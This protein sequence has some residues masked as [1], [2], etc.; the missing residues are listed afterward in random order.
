MIQSV[1]GS[2][3]QAGFAFA[4]PAPLAAPAAKETEASGNSN[5]SASTRSAAKTEKS[6]PASTASVDQLSS[7]EQQQL[8]QLKQIDRLVRAHEQAHLVVGSNLVRGGASFAYQTGPDDQRYAVGGE[9]SIDASPAATP[10][11]TIPKAQHIR[12]AALAPA[13]PSPQDQIVAAVAGRMEGE[14]RME[15]ALRQS[16]SASSAGQGSA[17]FYQGVEQNVSGHA[18]LGEGLDIFA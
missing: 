2:S 1:A 16:G 15:L 3:L 4:R 14:A 7:Q 11:E 6:S 8:A 13:D 5:D 17:D 12:A 18:R 9:V 10:E